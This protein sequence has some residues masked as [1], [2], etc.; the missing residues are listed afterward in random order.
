MSLPCCALGN[1]MISMPS[2]ELSLKS[3]SSIR[4]TQMKTQGSATPQAPSP[5]ISEQIKEEMS[6]S[7]G[8][9][10]GRQQ[11]I[12]TQEK[13]FSDVEKVGK[14][15]KGPKHSVGKGWVFTLFFAFSFLQELQRNPHLIMDGVSRFDIMQGEVGKV[16]FL[17]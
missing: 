13:Q 14:V 1:G 8:F 9:V 7:S 3:V 12:R 6:I 4:E 5:G 2:S 11:N 17:I 16:I 15:F 10:E